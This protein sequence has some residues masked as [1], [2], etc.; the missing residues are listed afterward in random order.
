MDRIPVKVKRLE[1][2]NLPLPEYKTT[3]SA[4][5]DLSACVHSEETLAPGEIKLIPT[6]LTFEIPEGYELQIRPRSG[7]AA[8]NGI[9]IVNTPGTID[10]DYRGEVKIILVNLSQTPFVINRGERIAQAVLNAAP[11][12]QLIETE[13]LSGTTRGTGGFGHTG[14]NV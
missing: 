1:G 2:N 5:F 6:G 3:G 13:E 12:A 11:Q 8:K 14:V 7:L 4:G 10:S 9:S